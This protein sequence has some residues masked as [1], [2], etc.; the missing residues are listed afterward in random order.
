[1]DTEKIDRTLVFAVAGV[2]YAVEF[3]TVGKY[4]AIETAKMRLSRGMYGDMAASYMKSSAIALDHIDAI[5]FFSVMTPELIDDLKV[6]IE[7]LDI[8]DAKPLVDTYR[9]V[10]R[11]WVDSWMKILSS[12]DKADETGK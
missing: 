6:K 10:I 3:P 4:M 7:D 11:P 8:M 1:M 9:N 5:S 12:P 2:G